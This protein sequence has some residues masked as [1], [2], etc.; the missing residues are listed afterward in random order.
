MQVQLQVAQKRSASRLTGFSLIEL[1]IV[2]ALIA[3]VLTVALVSS[4][5]RDGEKKLRRGT[6][7]ISGMVRRA[8][9]FAM[10]QQKVFLVTIEPN[11]IHIGAMQAP[12]QEDKR[13]LRTSLR[14]REEEV[15]PSEVRQDFAPINESESWDED[16]K[17]EIKRWGS[18]NWVEIEDDGDSQIKVRQ[19]LRFEPSGI[20][21]PFAIR[22]TSK[23]GYIMQEFHPLSASVS[24]EEFEIR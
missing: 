19:V 10:L 20:S 3:T 13:R 18:K 7:A 8:R 23:D 11:Q 9:A 15:D 6:D 14:A 24:N 5:G 4:F 1:V 12:P 16:L 21:E 22:V 17:I 2:M